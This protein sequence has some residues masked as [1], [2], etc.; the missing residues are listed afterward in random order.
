MAQPL[1]MWPEAGCLTPVDLGFRGVYA[2]PPLMPPGPRACVTEFAVISWKQNHAHLK[3]ILHTLFVGFVFGYCFQDLSVNPVI[4]PT[5]LSILPPLRWINSLS[6]LSRSKYLW[7]LCSRSHNWQPVKPPGNLRKFRLK[8]HF[9]MWIVLQ[10]SQEERSNTR[11][12]NPS[13]PHP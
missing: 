2:K 13:P 12:L 8:A 6:T 11:E 9:E 3:V 10:T 7:L 1:A 4:N 5:G